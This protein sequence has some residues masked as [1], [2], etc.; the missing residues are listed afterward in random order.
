MTEI[1]ERCA[2]VLAGIRYDEINAQI[3]DPGTRA[4]D[5][6]QHFVDT[7]WQRFEPTA[8]TVIEAMREDIM[9]WAYEASGCCRPGMET[10]DYMGRRLDTALTEGEG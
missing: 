2:R 9:R 4:I 7:R 10:A 5:A 3:T 8:R 1:V 6:R